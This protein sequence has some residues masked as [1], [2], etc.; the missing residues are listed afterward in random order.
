MRL[1]NLPASFKLMAQSEIANENVCIHILN[2]GGINNCRFF[3]SVVL[4][5]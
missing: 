4:S 2:S 3:F 1:L 5:F